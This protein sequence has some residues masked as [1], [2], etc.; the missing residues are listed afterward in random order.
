M[1]RAR[2]RN[3]IGPPSA[4]LGLALLSSAAI[5]AS[6]A[7]A[8]SSRHSARHLGSC[9][10]SPVEASRAAKR[11]P[12]HGSATARSELRLS[13]RGE[14]I[15][16]ALRLKGGSEAAIGLPVESFVAAQRGSAVVYTRYGDGRGSEVHLVDLETGCDTVIA[17]PPEIVRSA[18]LDPDASAI[19]VH[20]VMKGS[21]RDGGVTRYD[22]ASGAMTP[23]VPALQPVQRI[24]PIHGTELRWSV[25]G[26]SLT[27]QSCGF[28]ECTS[29][30]LEVAEGELAHIDGAGQG[31]LVGTTDDHLIT[32]ASCPGLPCAVLS[33][34]LRS[35]ART[36]IA[37]EALGASVEGG[38]GGRALLSIVTAE[39]DVEVEL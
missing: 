31:A 28:A 17:R 22:L 21:R 10:D 8:G 15:G 20:S 37:A 7:I 6:V 13:P 1:V 39:G 24:G 27:V 9:P 29:R 5:T 12:A 33:F 26:G 3:R 2:W 16:R 4:L 25:S 18:M 34:D 19:Y 32:F 11:E 14:V 38:S 30:V 35:G 36:V 23:V